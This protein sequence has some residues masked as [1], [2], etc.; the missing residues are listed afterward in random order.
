MKCKN[1]KGYYNGTEPSPKGYG[2]CAKNVKAGIVKKGT[3]NNYWVS[4]I[5]QV[6]NSPIKRW[7]RTT[8]RV[9]STKSRSRKNRK[10]KTRSRKS[11]CLNGKGY[12]TGKEPSPKGLGQCSRNLK[13]GTKQVGKDKNNW[14]VR[15]YK[16]RGKNIK[17]WVRAKETLMDIMNKRECVLCSLIQ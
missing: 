3:D 11:K 14:I 12:Y 7:V 17:R 15:A 8:K 10:G 1:G 5:I 4:K 16:I 2:Y 13:I 9:A 6:H